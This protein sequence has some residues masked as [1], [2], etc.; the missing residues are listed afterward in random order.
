MCLLESTLR[1]TERLDLSLAPYRGIPDIPFFPDG[2]HSWETTEWKELP[3]FAKTFSVNKAI[4]EHYVTTML[5][6]TISLL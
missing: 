3:Q 5:P 4:Y 1:E 6:S 2:S